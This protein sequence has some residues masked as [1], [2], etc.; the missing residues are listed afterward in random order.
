[1]PHK[2]AAS[3]PWPQWEVFFQ[4]LLKGVPA[5]NPGSC[6]G[7]AGSTCCPGSQGR[8]ECGDLGSDISL[9]SDGTCPGRRCASHIFEAW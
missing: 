8:F 1:M 6:A 9:S 7:C 2:K 4:Q 5:G 3:K